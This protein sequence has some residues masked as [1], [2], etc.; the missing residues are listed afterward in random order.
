VRLARF[1]NIITWPLATHMNKPLMNTPVQSDWY[2][3]SAVVL[4]VA[5]FLS[6]IFVHFRVS[7]DAR[8]T[9]RTWKI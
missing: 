1:N 2:V 7:F 9:G 6:P 4:P 3:L 8:D 5:F